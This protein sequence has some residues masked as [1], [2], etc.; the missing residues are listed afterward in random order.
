M[1]R[2]YVGA[3]DSLTAITNIP[4]LNKHVHKSLI[5]KS[6]VFLNVWLS[7]RTQTIFHTN[8]SLVS[9]N[10]LALHFRAFLQETQTHIKGC[11]QG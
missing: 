8:F 3:K 6:T 11:S 10:K 5:R 4:S 2:V 7:L 1:Q 9:Y